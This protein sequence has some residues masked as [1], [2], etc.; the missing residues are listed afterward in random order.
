MKVSFLPVN[1][2]FL[3]LMYGIAC[4]RQSSVTEVDLSY[5]RITL[6]LIP[7]L[8]S[9]LGS[10]CSSNFVNWAT[11]TTNEV[12]EGSFT[13]SSTC[14]S[15]YQSKQSAP[16]T[17]LDRSETS[18]VCLSLLLVDL[19]LPSFLIIFLGSCLTL[20]QSSLSGFR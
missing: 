10:S 8:V 5:D 14:A 7:T 9:L 16:T 12:L 19:K 3:D 17:P 15:S 6:V 11:L 2:I 13:N 20:T 4:L 1:L 18:S